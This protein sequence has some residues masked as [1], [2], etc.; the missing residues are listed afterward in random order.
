MS[1]PHDC[2]ATYEFTLS[3]RLGPVLRA[4]FADQRITTLEPCTVIRLTDAGER[5]LVDVLTLFDSAQVSVR[6]VHEVRTPVAGEP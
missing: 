2:P 3:G 4:V 1:R 5:D 6:E